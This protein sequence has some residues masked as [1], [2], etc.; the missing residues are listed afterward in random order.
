MRHLLCKCEN[1]SSHTQN[2]NKA[3]CRG[4]QLSSVMRWETPEAIRPTSSLV[5]AA[6]NKRD[7]VLDKVTRRLDI[8][9]LHIHHGICFPCQHPH[10]THI[11]T[12][13]ER[14]TKRKGVNGHRRSKMIS[15]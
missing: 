14:G 10:P 4:A 11:C 8:Y 3:R 6:V 9:T 12:Q 7:P 2:S 5:Y 13:R 15:S 1:Q